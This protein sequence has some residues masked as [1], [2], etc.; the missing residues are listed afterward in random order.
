MTIYSH[1]RLSSFEQCPLKYKLKYIDKIKPEV[2]KTIESHLGNCAHCTLEW[3]YKIILEK[4]PTPS[5]EEVIEYYCKEW[6]TQY[7]ED[8]LIVKKNLTQKDYF[9][10]GVKFLID[11]Y[12]KHKPFVDGT[13]ELEKKIMITLGENGQYKLTGFIDRLVYNKEKDEYE[14][15]DYKTAN[16]LPS[17]EKVKNDRQLALYSIG[18]KDLFGKE[19][20]MLLTWHYLAHDEQI[21]S[22]RTDSELEELKCKIMALIDK[23]EAT[24]NFPAKE[25]MLCHWCEFKPICPNHGGVLPKSKE[26]NER[27]KKEYPTIS[28]YI[29]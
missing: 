14:I 13:L 22:R 21:F 4:A 20:S 10:K 18:I 6:E 16:S 25:S 24:E 8:V 23:I 26:E 7:T 9:N 15:H 11:Y 1:S 5:L 28:R 3:L 19:K 17:K 29:K 27:L 12:Q 2:E